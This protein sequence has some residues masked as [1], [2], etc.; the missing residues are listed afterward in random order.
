MHGWLVVY[1]FQHEWSTE[2]QTIYI[3]LFCYVVS[4]GNRLGN[5]SG[6]LFWVGMPD[7]REM[8]TRSKG[9]KQIGEKAPAPG[10]EIDEK[11]TITVFQAIKDL[12]ILSET[13]PI[14]NLKVTDGLLCERCHSWHHRTCSKI[15]KT[16]YKE[17]SNS[18][19]EYVCPRCI[20]MMMKI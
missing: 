4:A 6:S 13:C 3:Q 14:C 18:V 20:T 10:T 11:T 1:L 12:R 9:G 5:S 8:D 2:V 16:E 17:L 7:S 19:D 15:S